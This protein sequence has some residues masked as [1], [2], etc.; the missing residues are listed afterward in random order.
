MVLFLLFQLGSQECFL[1]LVSLFPHSS[2]E[3]LHFIVILVCDL[4]MKNFLFILL[5][6]S[7][8]SLEMVLHATVYDNSNVWFE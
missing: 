6:F 2:L 4:G 3:V 1:H 5:L 8:G 7:P